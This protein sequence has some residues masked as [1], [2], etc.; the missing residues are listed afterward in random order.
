M[1]LGER[2]GITTQVLTQAKFAYVG[3]RHLRDGA[4]TIC[5]SIHC[6]IMHDDEI[7][8]RS[9]MDVGLHHVNA[10][11]NAVFESCDRVLRGLCKGMCRCN[12]MAATVRHYND[13]V[14]FGRE[15]LLDAA[16]LCLCCA[17]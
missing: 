5:R 12:L 3:K 2:F 8:V 16:A 7:S 11:C 10:H 14:V 17:E 4:V 15:Q 1:F 9:H 6:R 13:A